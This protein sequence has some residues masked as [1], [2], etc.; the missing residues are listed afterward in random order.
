MKEK[1][2]QVTQ[3]Q[4]EC[5]A[6]VAAEKA[7]EAYRL[8]ARKAKRRMEDENVRITKRKLQAYRRTKASLSEGIEFT[9]DEKIELRWAFIRDFM[10]SDFDGIAKAEDSIKA[11]ENK[12]NRDTF[13]VQTIERALSLYR[14]EA[15]RSSSEEFK[16]RHRE[17]CAMYVDE[18]ERTIGEIAE[19]ESVS[20]KIVYRDIRIACGILAVYLLGM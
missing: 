10:G 6:A 3:E 8:E 15:D 13:E 1:K 17:L 7:V 4:L 11:F 14:R 16:R 5:M 18:E 2:Y 9:D 20:E 19:M 12:R